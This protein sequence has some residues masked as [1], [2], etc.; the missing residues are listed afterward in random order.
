MMVELKIARTKTGATNADDYID[1]AGYI[2]IAGE[3]ALNGKESA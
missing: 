2:G 1:A 3:I